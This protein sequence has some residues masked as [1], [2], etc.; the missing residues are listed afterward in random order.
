[1]SAAPLI[2]HGPGCHRPAPQLRLSWLNEAEAFCTACGRYGPAPDTR[3]PNP[4]PTQE[5]KK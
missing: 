4:T 3:T 1:M 2:T 5:T